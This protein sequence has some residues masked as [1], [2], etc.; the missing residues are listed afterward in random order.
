MNVRIGGFF[1]KKNLHS[2]L[3]SVGGGSIARGVTG[4]SLLPEEVDIVRGK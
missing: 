2:K 3:T 4:L 1:L